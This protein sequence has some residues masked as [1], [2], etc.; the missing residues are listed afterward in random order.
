[1]ALKLLQYFYLVMTSLLVA[2]SRFTFLNIRW[3]SATIKHLILYS[4]GDKWDLR[5]PKKLSIN[6]NHSYHQ[7]SSPE[8]T[9]NISN[10][11]D[12]VSI[13]PLWKD[14]SRLVIVIKC[15]VLRYFYCETITRTTPNQGQRGTFTPWLKTNPGGHQTSIVFCRRDNRDNITLRVACAG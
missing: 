3:H 12:S 4:S 7:C 15:L 10:D 5:V 9:L 14:G 2:A 6:I 13:T 8:V 1:M 11:L